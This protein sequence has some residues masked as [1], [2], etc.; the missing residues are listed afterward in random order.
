M[1]FSW[2][3][4]VLVAEVGAISPF[5][6]AASHSTTSRKAYREWVTQQKSNSKDKGNNPNQSILGW[7]SWTGGERAT[8][9]GVIW[10]GFS[11]LY[12]CMVCTGGKPEQG[13][14]NYC[15]LYVPYIFMIMMIFCV[16]PAYSEELENNE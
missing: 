2:K 13:D 4:T 10:F 12:L 7:D 1:W 6:F 9:V 3:L 16:L 15:I 11:Y 8:Y 5:D 14:N